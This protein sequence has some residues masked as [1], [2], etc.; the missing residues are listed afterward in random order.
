MT[1]LLAVV[2]SCKQE[3]K[4]QPVAVS[5]VSPDSLTNLW[6]DAWNQHDSAAIANMF[7]ANA[8]VVFSDKEKIVGAAAIMAQWVRQNLPSTKKLITENTASSSTADMAYYAGNYSLDYIKKDS[9]EGNEKACF[10][11][12]WKKQEDNNWKVELM[13]FGVHFEE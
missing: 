2:V 8:T 11:A 6:N 7:A 4:P 3:T 13:F 12:I 5:V 9:S 1:V 10:T